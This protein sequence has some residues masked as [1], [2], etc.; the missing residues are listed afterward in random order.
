M[1]KVETDAVA[2]FCL[3]NPTGQEILSTR[4]RK[5]FEI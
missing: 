5:A 1:S 4:K 3:E 2:R